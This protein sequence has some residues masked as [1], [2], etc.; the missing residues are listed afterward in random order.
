MEPPPSLEPEK[1]LDELDDGFESD[2]EDPNAFK[3]RDALNP[4]SANSLSTAELH[5]ELDNIERV[6]IICK[7]AVDHFLSPYSPYTRR[8]DR[9]KPLIPAR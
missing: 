5:G 7:D 6:F 2:S 3:I 8:S 9:F 1:L 4:P